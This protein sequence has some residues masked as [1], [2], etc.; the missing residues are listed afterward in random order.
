MLQETHDFDFRDQRKAQ[1][2]TIAA[3]SPGP[4]LVSNYLLVKKR[5]LWVNRSTDQGELQQLR[6]K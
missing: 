5:I 6:Y 2:L 4:E 3:A 1:D